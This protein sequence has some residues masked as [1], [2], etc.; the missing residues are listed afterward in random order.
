[1]MSEKRSKDRDHMTSGRGR[2]SGWF[3]LPGLNKA[4]CATALVSFSALASFATCNQLDLTNVWYAFIHF[5][6]KR[7]YSFH[8]IL[9]KYLWLKKGLNLCTI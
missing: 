2:E 6:R 7:A 8:Q 1:M 5:W 9:K 3:L 4:R